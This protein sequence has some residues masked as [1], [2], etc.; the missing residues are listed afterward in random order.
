MTN[1]YQSFKSEIIKITDE[2]SN[3]KTFTLKPS[4]KFS[5]KTGQFI[6]FSLNGI[7]EAPVTPSSSPF[8]TD[9]IDI[10]IMKV[11]YVTEKI[12]QLK[13]GDTVGIRGPYGKGYPLEN[14]FDKEILILGGGVGMAPLRSLLLTLIHQMDRFKRIILCYGAKSPEDIIYKS[15]FEEWKKVKNLEVL[16]SV[17]KCQSGKWGGDIGV[18]TCLLDKVNIN[19]KNTISIVCGPPIM[20]KFG[21][22]KLLEIG[23]APEQ[24]YLSMEKNMSCGLGK[25]GHCQIG[26]YF[27][28][29]DGPVFTY[30]QIKD[31]EEL[32]D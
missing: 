12:H 31:Y 16:R 8:E 30:E 27:V 4:E 20:M 14:M 18:V 9:T 5:F 3:I 21:T 7:G 17:D 22:R 25:C 2:S 13:S 6:E 1:I 28:C 29:K 11:G 32:W 23:F 15:Q 24:I 26:P 19:L 10:T